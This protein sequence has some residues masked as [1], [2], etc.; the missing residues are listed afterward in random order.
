MPGW[1]VFLKRSAAVGGVGA[2]TLAGL[3]YYRS[4]SYF[5][6][7]GNGAGVGPAPKLP[8]RAAMIKDMKSEEYDVLVL[9]GGSVGCGVA[10]DASTRGLKVA[11]IERNDFGSGTSGASTKLLHGGV[12]YLEKAVKQL[13]VGQL[14]LVMEAL[15][16]RASMM[17]QAPHLTKPIGI[18]TPL[19]SYIDLPQFVIGLK[20]YDILSGSRHIANSY[21]VNSKD[22]TAKFPLIKQEGLKGSV[23]YYDGQFDDARFNV[24]LAL[25]GAERGVKL[26][27]HTE[28]TS[29]VHDEKTKK[30]TGAIVRDVFTG[31]EYTVKAKTV[32]NAT[33]SFG[34]VVRKLDATDSK[35]VVCN[36][37]GTHI[38]LDKKWCADDLGLLIPKT[39]DGRVVFLLPWRGS[40]LAGTTDSPCEA[41]EQPKPTADQ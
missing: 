21:Y 7:C 8:T 40:T 38:M 32:V 39:D 9:G 29:L 22:T 5:K 4:E 30:V 37:A 12:R 19:Y 11:V 31:S 34:D 18:I 1:S 6:N 10:L 2:A 27:N 24:S 14:H 23:I 13:D 41:I 28:V 17:I 35:P 33:G 15:H 25:T 26:A 3:A 20:L 36:A 16:E